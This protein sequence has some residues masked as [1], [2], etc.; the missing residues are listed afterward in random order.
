MN[1]II[2][3]AEKHDVTEILRLVKEL[4]IFEKAPNEVINTESQMI[5]DGFGD[6]PLFKCILAENKDRVIG[7]ALYYYRY[8]TWKGKC[9]YLEDLYVLE[10]FRQNGVGQMLFSEIKNRA[11][12]ENCIRINWQ[13]LDWNEPAIKFYEKNKAEFDKEWWNGFI[14]L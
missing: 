2:R 7:F 8:S 14:N 13:V 6:A 1:I 12:I 3:P 11:K 9:L 5:K 4:A 10:D